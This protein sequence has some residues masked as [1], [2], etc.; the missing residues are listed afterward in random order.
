[1]AALPQISSYFPASNKKPWLLKYRSARPFLL[2]TVCMAVFADIF[3]YAVIIPV[4]PFSLQSR[5][6]VPEDEGK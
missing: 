6:G 1:M 5:A 2:L 3:L 4:V